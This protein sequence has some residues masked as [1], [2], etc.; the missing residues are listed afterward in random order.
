MEK[1][2]VHESDRKK[3]EKENKKQHREDVQQKKIEKL[4]KKLLEVGYY[5]LPSG[6]IDKVHADKW[7]GKAKNYAD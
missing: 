7:L 1:I 4:E 3:H 2:R 6:R 5:N